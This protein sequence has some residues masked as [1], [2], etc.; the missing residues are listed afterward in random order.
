MTT[1]DTRSNAD[2]DAV[3]QLLECMGYSC[4]PLA[5]V[6]VGKKW[7]ACRYLGHTTFDC[8]LRTL[9]SLGMNRRPPGL[10]ADPIFLLPGRPSTVDVSERAQPRTDL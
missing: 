9:N 5:L 1:A 3:Q 10:G 6:L 4:A 7:P 8:T 2:R